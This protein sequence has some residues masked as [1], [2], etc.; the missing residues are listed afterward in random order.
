MYL[1]VAYWHLVMNGFLGEFICKLDA[2][3]RFVLPASFRRQLD[4]ETRLSFVL[5][6]A[7]F[8]PC[9]ELYTQ[10]AFDQELSLIK[11]RVNR[12]TREGDDLRRKFF[13]GVERLI[14]DSSDRLLL[15]RKRLDHLGAESEVLLVGQDGWIEIWEPGAYEQVALSPEEYAASAERLLGGSTTG[16]EW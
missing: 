13:N 6:S 1:S 8:Q 9:L 7:P 2:K 16:E 14:L 3:G 5:K 10:Q 12:Y 15:T 4:D 11:N